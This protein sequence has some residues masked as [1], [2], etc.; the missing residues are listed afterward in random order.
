[1]LLSLEIQR[2]P[3]VNRNNLVSLF[4]GAAGGLVGGLTGLGGG[5]IMIPMMTRF[6]RLVQHQ[7]HGTSLAI[8]AVVGLSAASQ[9]ALQGYLDWPLAAQLALGSCLGVI[10]GAKIM[11][12]VPAAQLRRAFGIFLIIVAL[13]MLSGWHL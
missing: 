11:M 10:L 13:V 3:R 7:A 6:L 5:V 8:I 12:R 4:I 1:M 2:E 9:Y